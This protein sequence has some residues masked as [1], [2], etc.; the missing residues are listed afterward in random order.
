VRPQLGVLC[1]A[2]DFTV[3]IS[4]GCIGRGPEHLSCEERLRQLRLF[5]LEKRKFRGHLTMAFQYLEGA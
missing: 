2:L 3:P 5:R 1:P 4:H